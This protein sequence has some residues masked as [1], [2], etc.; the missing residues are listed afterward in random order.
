LRHVPRHDFDRL[1]KEHHAG[2]PLRSIDRWSQFAALA[3]AHLACRHSL[4]DVVANLAAQSP[5]LY[6]LGVRPV[7]RSSLSRVNAEQP[8]TLYE[9]L[10]AELYQRCRR[11]APRHGFRFKNKLYSLDSSLIDLSLAVFPWAHYALGKAAMKLHVGLDHDGFLPAFAAVTESKV[12]DLAYARSLRLARGSIV[13]FDKGY[14]DYAWLKALDDAGV[15]FVTRARANIEATAVEERTPPRGS[16]V[17][18]DRSVRL[19]GKRP[20]A[21]NMPGLRAI[22]FTCPET[23]RNYVF[24]TNIFH[25]SARTIADLYKQRWQV[26]L[27]FKWL[28]QNLKM[29]GFLGTT[30][31]AVLT[32][33]WVA[34]CIALL[35]AYLKFV[36]RI[37]LGTQAI[38]RLLQLNL[39]VRRDLFELL[40]KP[41]TDPP[42]PPR[43]WSLAL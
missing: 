20:Q 33:I 23:G 9:A 24:L 4:R 28:K 1:A 5:R 17:T 25:L 13:V 32:Q 16:G 35:L 27:F 40:N 29:R 41:P 22:G 14:S 26:E 18:S 36:T 39:F 2:A 10:F 19:D 12:N 15:F 11:L 43:Q 31:N 8:Y 37:D 42:Q 7:A 30:R 3:T 6:H 21:M 34:L 38:L